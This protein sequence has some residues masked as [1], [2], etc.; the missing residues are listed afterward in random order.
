M[1]IFGTRF[2]IGKIG[3]TCPVCNGRGS[4]KKDEYAD[5]GLSGRDGTYATGRKVTEY[6]PACHGA[7]KV[8]SFETRRPTWDCSMCGGSGKVTHQRWNL[9]PDGSR[10]SIKW[11]REE[12]CP[13]CKGAGKFTGKP[14]YYVVPLD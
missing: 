2:S 14:E 4:W 8:K 6:C 11:E 9:Y 3:Q 10:K 1:R 5:W 7:G 12:R 13:D